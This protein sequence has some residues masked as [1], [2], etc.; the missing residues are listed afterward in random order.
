MPITAS[1]AR[2]PMLWPIKA[3]VPPRP[4]EIR[5][6]FSSYFLSHTKPEKERRQGFSD[7]PQGGFVQTLTPRR[8]SVTLAFPDPD[9]PGRTHDDLWDARGPEVPG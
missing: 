3:L 8:E 4:H 9:R 6:R 7:L 5:V 1:Q 2:G